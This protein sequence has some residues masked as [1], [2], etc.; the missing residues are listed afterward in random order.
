MK[1]CPIDANTGALAI[2]LD[3]ADDPETSL[4]LSGTSSNTTLVPNA[5]ILF[6]GSGANRTVTITPA[7]G[8]LGMTNIILTVSDGALIANRSFMLTVTGTAQKT[9]RF[10]Q[11]GNADNAGPADPDGDG[12]LNLDEYAAGTDP[13]NTSDVFRILATTKTGEGFTATAAGKASRSYVL[14]RRGDLDSGPWTPVT[15]AGPLAA[16]GPVNLTDPAPPVGSAFYRMRVSA[17]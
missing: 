16:D 15:S 7:S 6:G 5:N 4:V 3:D 8:Q 9:W 11:F 1:A 13:N 17:P 2:T 12:S 10:S 14:E